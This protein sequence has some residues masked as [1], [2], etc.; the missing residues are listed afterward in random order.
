MLK[1][2]LAG[3]GTIRAP[4]S[5]HSAFLCQVHGQPTQDRRLGMNKVILRAVDIE[6]LGLNLHVDTLGASLE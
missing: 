4:S 2:I 6:Y 1:V 5:C 3:P